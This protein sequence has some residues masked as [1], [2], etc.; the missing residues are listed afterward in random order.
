M[1]FEGAEKKAEVVVSKDYIE[2]HGSLKTWPRE[3]WEKLVA[4]S[5]AQIMSEV[6]NDKLSAYLLSESSLFVWE[7]RIV[8]ITC[9]QTT[10]ANA[11]ECFFEFCAPENIECLIFERKNEY[12]PEDQPSDFYSDVVRLNKHLNGKGYLFGEEK[13]R[14]LYL[15][16]MNKEFVPPENDVT[17]EVLMYG[18][19]GESREVF[20]CEKQSLENLR[21]LTGIHEILPG[22]QV[23]DFLFEP[24]GYS[25]N[26]IKDT[27]YYTIHVTPQ[28][29]CPYVSFETNA[30]VN[31]SYAELVEKVI[32]IFKPEKFEVIIFRSS[33]QEFINLPNYK[34]NK[35]VKQKLSCGYIVN[36][37]QFD[38]KSLL[39]DDAV[40]KIHLSDEAKILNV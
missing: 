36:Y 5:N 2:K 11:V 27:E 12:F 21:R 38:D 7:N 37:C 16:H 31:G 20:N 19:Q 13:D 25:I 18:L 10:L 39:K 15:Y 33:L 30:K 23:D 26:A 28:D 40:A 3:R 4:A 6:H 24:C 34:I 9:G 14:H 32:K 22:Y 1:V 8:L 29:Q 35:A 17:V